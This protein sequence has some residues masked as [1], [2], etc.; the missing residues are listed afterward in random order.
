MGP[1]H[2]VKIVEL[3][4][5]GPGPF[6]AMILADLGA[7]IV[8]LDRPG[9][10]RLVPSDAPD[11]V[12]RG[13]PSVP[14]DLKSEQGRELAL[15]LCESADAVIEG[16]RPGVIERLGLGPDVLQ[17]RNP[18]LVVGRITGYGQE[19]PLALVPG[20]DVNYISIS[21]ALGTMAREGERP[22]F[23]LN[24]LGDY[25]GGGML[26]AL[27]VLA[28]VFEARASGRGQV[29]DAAMVDGSA[30]LTTVIHGLR[31]GG[32]WSDTPGTNILD[33]GA[34]FYE[35]Y[36]T[37][38]GGYISVGAIETQFY[39][40][41]LR[42]LELD[43]AAY[44]Q[45]D[46][47]RWPELKERF[48]AIFRTRTRAEWAAALEPADACATPVLTLDEAVAHPHN[49]ARATFVEVDG[50]TQPAAAP[51]F[52]RTPGHAG[53]PVPEPAAALT[54]WGLDDDAVA[55]ALGVTA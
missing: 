38:D 44:P 13:R 33:S 54:A 41:L 14:A 8:R 2:G 1:L 47:A 23:P 42:I 52:S 43:P 53:R 7:E 39:A 51:R 18:R 46:R 32:A 16:V 6:A 3:G 26:L 15:R 37:Q 31:A 28:A 48:A 4:S 19:G 10:A 9:Q 22:L 40:D 24:F 25:G 34:H 12:L 29:V 35:V 36:E 11:P 20:H 27:G 45:W 17:S 55:A 21:G 50:L 5:I 49:V 30:L